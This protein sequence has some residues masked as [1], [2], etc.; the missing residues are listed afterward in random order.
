MCIYIY[1]HRYVDPLGAI[2][3]DIGCERSIVFVQAFK[4]V[5]IQCLKNIY[6]YIYVYIQIYVYISCAIYIYK[7]I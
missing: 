3:A 5:P 1:I 6:I 2:E 4:R 7:Y